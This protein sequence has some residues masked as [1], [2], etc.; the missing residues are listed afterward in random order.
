[1]IPKEVQANE[2][3]IE[4]PISGWTLQVM[5]TNWAG[6]WILQL[7]RLGHPPLALLM[8]L[9]NLSDIC[10]AIRSCIDAASN[11]ENY[12][13][14]KTMFVTAASDLPTQVSDKGAVSVMT[15]WNSDPI[16]VLSYY[17]GGHGEGNIIRQVLALDDAMKLSDMFATVYNRFSDKQS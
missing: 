14:A 8:H 17:R 3:L 10:R 11:P 6:Y 5:S 4:A 7:T 15:E 12:P 2:L 13:R 16:M 9:D 1:M